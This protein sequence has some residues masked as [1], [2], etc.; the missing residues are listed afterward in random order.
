[1]GNIKISTKNIGGTEKASVQL[2][3]GSVNIIEG[4]SF[5]GKSS[6]M[7]G[8][9]L[10]LVGAPNVHRDE[11]EKLQLNAT[12]QSKPKPDSPLLRRGSSE[13]LVVIEHDGV[14]IEAKLPMNGRISGKGSNE[15][16]VYTSMLSDLPKTSLYSA[17]FDGENGDDFEW[18]STVVSEAK[19]Y[20]VWQNV[21]RP[22][23]QELVTIRAKFEQWKSSKGDGDARKEEIGEKLDELDEEIDVL[24]K[25]QGVMDDKKASNLKTA[26][27]QHRTHAAEYNRLSTLVQG[28][29]V[30][31]ESQLRRIAAAKAQK[32]IAVRR[33][34]EAEDLENTELIEPDMIKL[35]T[36][37][38]KAQKNVED[39][40][41]D[42][43]P[44]VKKIV[45]EYL[46]VKDS[47]PPSLAKVIEMAQKELGD[48]SKLTAALE[49]LGKVKAEK[50]NEVRKFMETRSKIGSA[51]QMAAAARSEIKAANQTIAD[52]N[53]NM[54]AKAADL[55]K[56]E[57]D[58]AKSE[59]QYKKS[60]KEV[61][62][63]Q[64]EVAGGDSAEL[65][66]LTTERKDLQDEKDSLESST[67]FE[68][69]LT[70]L[71]MMPNEGI[72]L[73]ED[74]GEH[75]L[76]DGSGGKSRKSLVNSNLTDI[77]SAEV[78]SLIKAE[79]DNGIL[80]D[81]G[82]T[83][84]WVSETVENQQ[85]QTR[86]IFNE[87]G[88]TLFEKMPNSR[89]KSVE[90]NTD[91]EIRQTWDDGQTTGLTG[92]GGER[93]LTAAAI[94]IAMRKAFTPDIPILMI[95][96][97]LE[98]LDVSKRKILLDFLKDYAETDGVTIVVSLLNEKETE[99]KVSTL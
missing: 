24:R 72:L 22:I 9:L 5:S 40:S 23:N 80:V 94:L 3:S 1:M 70:S 58:L 43:N 11:I 37:V 38:Q 67:T 77:G 66:K 27:T 75:I 96:G 32:K 53:V 45:R 48:D 17:V 19:H 78:R 57:E 54:G 18:V 87:I 2:V 86:R 50:N 76:G 92:S 97:V 95:D 59:R 8:V 26:E 6:L 79:I 62:D 85:Q 31:N 44:T 34:D 51:S 65:K 14:K 52:A 69:R 15:K 91:Y 89:I 83:T 74:L 25:A 47:T 68:L 16:A 10:G 20:I 82:P 39:A 36:A 84:D 33:L 60:E 42:A 29:K 90:L 13:G 30:E 73:T 7:R 93:A 21:L 81:I 46:K 71:Q 88:T 35:E 55:P 99:V 12:E 61:A 63:L 98:K 56:N 4:T 49:E 41:G 28:L 64:A